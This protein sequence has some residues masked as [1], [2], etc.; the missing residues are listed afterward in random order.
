ML[1]HLRGQRRR[2]NGR[3]RETGLRISVPRR[4][5]EEGKILKVDKIDAFSRRR[6]PENDTQSTSF[7]PVTD[8]G[9]FGMKYTLLERNFDLTLL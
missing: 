3:R 1:S 7:L 2:G 4:I 9:P 6:I 5:E 8:D